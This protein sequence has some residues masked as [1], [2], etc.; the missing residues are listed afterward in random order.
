[1]T[2]FLYSFAADNAHVAC[3]KMK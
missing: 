1:M 2:M 3:G